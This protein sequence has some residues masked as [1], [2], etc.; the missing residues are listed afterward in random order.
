MLGLIDTIDTVMG[1]VSSNL[2]ASEPQVFLVGSSSMA[3]TWGPWGEVGDRGRAPQGSAAQPHAHG[4][5]R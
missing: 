2:Q 1:H 5:R 3:G 4:A